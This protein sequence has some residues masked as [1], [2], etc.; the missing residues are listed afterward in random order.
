MCNLASRE[1]ILPKLD[2]DFE[3]VELK[4]NILVK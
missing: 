4:P 1:L 3:V 2:Y